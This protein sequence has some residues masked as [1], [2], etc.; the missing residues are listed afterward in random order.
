VL[1]FI[2]RIWFASET[3][4]VLSDNRKSGGLE[5]L[6]STPLRIEDILRGQWLALKRQF[7]GPVL[8]VIVVEGFF[9][10]A[11]VREAI[12]DDEQL[13]WYAIWFAGILMFVADLVALYWIC[14]WRGLTARNGLRAA[15]GSLGI[16]FGLPWIA[17]GVVLL[18]MILIE[19]GQQGNQS[20]PNWQFFLGLWFGL[21]IAVDFFFAAWCRQKLLTE[22]RLA[23]QRQHGPRTG[24]FGRWVATLKPRLSGMDPGSLDSE[25]RM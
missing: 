6:L 10:A 1:N 7:L 14:M 9:M 13:F 16:V 17:Y 15:G 25:V 4:G 3:A 18:F 8:A 23:A 12:P 21:G 22:F 20:S 24:S 19:W 2:L 5:L 11:T